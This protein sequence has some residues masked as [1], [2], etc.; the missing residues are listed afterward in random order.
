[1]LLEVCRREYSN[2]IILRGFRVF[3]IQGNPFRILALQLHYKTRNNN[4]YG[5]QVR[6]IETKQCPAINSSLLAVNNTSFCYLESIKRLKEKR[7]KKCSRILEAT[8]K[9]RT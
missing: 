7:K 1:M 9:P 5:R 6:P 2:P 4:N 8:C 3:N